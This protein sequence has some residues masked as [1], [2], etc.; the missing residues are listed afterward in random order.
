MTEEANTTSNEQPTD[1]DKTKATTDEKQTVPYGKFA[2]LQ[3][4]HNKLKD[5]LATI[6]RDLAAKLEQTDNQDV[7][8]LES[9]GQ[10]KVLYNQVLDKLRDSDAS[11]AKQAEL[12]TTYSEERVTRHQLLKAKLPENKQQFADGMNLTQLEEFVEIEIK[13]NKIRPDDK[14]PGKF[15]GH[16]SL[17]E[18]Q[19]TDP[20]GYAKVHTATGFKNITR[21]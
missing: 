16:D 4:E 17:A 10:Y 11:G 13:T 14:V 2:N 3:G 12:L 20:E 18:W 1:G 9:R 5:R 6:E 7:S 19:R 21:F 15:G 8:D